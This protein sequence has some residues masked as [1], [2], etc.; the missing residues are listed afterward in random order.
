MIGSRIGA[1]AYVGARR[2]TREGRSD[3]R[4]GGRISR[5]A[6]H[7]GPLLRGGARGAGGI[8]AGARGALPAALRG[9]LA[10][11]HQDRPGARAR[12]QDRYAGGDLRHRTAADRRQG[13]FRLAARRPW[14][15]A[16]LARGPFGFGF[17][18]AARRCGRGTAG[19][20]R[21][22]DR[23][24]L[25]FHRRAAA[26][27]AAGRVR[28]DGRNARRGACEPAAL[29]ARCGNAPAGVEGVLAAAGG[30]C[31][32]RH[33]QAHREH[34]EED[35]A[36]ERMLPSTPPRCTEAAERQLHDAL[37][38]CARPR[39][40][41]RRRSAAMRRVSSRWW[42]CGRRWTISSSASW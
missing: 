34:L 2:R 14:L 8:G 24:G 30:R 33:Q 37:R 5:T 28:H 40:G 38:E 12:R 31:S 20:A 11:R 7:H 9:R 21:G 1:G 17:V 25:R 15:V 32:R 16:H 23:R 39:A 13:P 29:A 3:D 36:R 10:A 26:R 22:R 27:L 41:R 4:H 19:T 35:L 42:P 6:G 18:R